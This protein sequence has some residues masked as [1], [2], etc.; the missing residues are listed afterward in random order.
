MSI[1]FDIEKFGR[2]PE[3][4]AQL[5]RSDDVFSLMR[6]RVDLPPA[7][8][9]LVRA[10]G[11]QAHHVPGG[12]SVEADGASEILFVR[13]TPV[14]LHYDVPSLRSEDGYDFSETV[15]LTICV[16]PERSEL[17]LLRKVLLGSGSRVDIGRIR[18]FCEEPVR[19]ALTEFARTRSAADL[20]AAT[21]W[22][23]FDAVLDER[24]K[25]VG[26]ASGLALG[27]DPRVTFAS[28]AFTESRRMESTAALRR[29][30]LEADAQLRSASVEAKRAHL[31][32]LQDVLS[33]ARALAERNDG[34]G[35]ASLLQ[36]FSAS[37]RGEL[38]L[39]LA[40]SNESTVRTEAILVVA[41]DELL[42]LDPSKLVEPVRRLPLDSPVG[43]LR[44]VRVAQ[45]G[46]RRTI[47]VGASRGIHVVDIGEGPRD[48]YACEES[49]AVRGGFNAASIIGERL[50]ATHSEIGLVSWRIGAPED[51]ELCLADLTE[52]ASTV[53]DV[54]SEDSGR[55]W[56]SVDDRLIGWRPDSDEPP[57]T[58]HAPD[59]IATSTI[60]DGF[61]IAGLGDGRVV[62]W[63]L[64]DLTAME[65]IRGPSRNK[66]RS[67]CW[68]SGGG[69][70]RL[71]IADGRS[72]LDMQVLGDA[73]YGVYRCA[74]AVRWGFGADDCIVGVN[75]NRDQVFVWRLHAPDEPAETVS[76]GRLCGHSIQDVALLAA[77]APDADDQSSSPPSA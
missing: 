46:D 17:E 36:T 41:G 33:K 39:A 75:A 73:H 49:T 5:V 40:A 21:T 20:S 57:C 22:D 25:P 11:G 77:A 10:R 61:V 30:R 52:G 37:E 66:V 55:L 8:A 70:P 71:L 32:Q 34:V 51:Q 26:F 67:I 14:D 48:T 16:V 15:E 69:V 27:P 12:G 23:K 13:T 50:F 28:P 29:Q 18:K 4:I 74:Q 9:A 59:V 72:H 60:C 3:T 45:A 19:S 58:I 2:Q 62:R 1:Q 24:F 76:I 64:M 38:Y 44:S 54:Q 31:S 56:F 43:G 68:M 7:C 6:R 35:V 63:P 42:W 65:T 53:R 47:L